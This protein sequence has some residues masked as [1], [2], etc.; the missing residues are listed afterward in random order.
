MDLG[1]IRIHTDAGAQAAAE[2]LRAKAFTVGLDIAFGR[3]QYQP[4]SGQGR[5]L[6]AHELSHV[7]LDHTGIHRMMIDN[8]ESSY[9]RAE[10]LRPARERR[11]KWVGLVEG[12]FTPELGR[13]TQTVHE[14]L[15]RTR[16][17]V[18]AQRAAA[19]DAAAGWQGWLNWELIAQGYT[20]PD[21]KEL[22]Q[23]WGEAFVAAEALAMSVGHGDVSGDAMLVA[24]AT[25][26]T[27][28]GRLAGFAKVVERA[29]QVR[30]DAENVRREATYRQKL[31][32]YELNLWNEKVQRESGMA[33]EPG[34]RA[35]LGG[36]AL[37]RGDRPSPPERVTPP[38]GVTSEIPA[39][40]ARI[41]AAE[42]G[43][44][45]HTVAEDLTRIG[46][47]FVGLVIATLPRESEARQGVEYVEKLEERLARLETTYEVAERIPAVFYPEDRIITKPGKDGQTQVVAEAI[48]WQFYLIDTGVRSREQPAH[49]G[50]EWI[51][52]DIT[53]PKHYDNKQPST[54]HEAA[55]FQQGEINPP[56][57]LF[58][59]LNSRLR[60]PKGRLYFKLGRTN[61]ILETTEPW[62]LSDF[63]SALSMVLGAI[64]LVAMV[65][66]TGGAAAPAAVAFIAG[67]GAIGAGI[68][69]QVARMHELSEQGA[70][71]DKDVEEAMIS[72][73]IDLVSLLSMG[74]GRLVAAPRTAARLGFT[75]ERFIT[76][77]KVTQAARAGAVLGDLYQGYALTKGL[78]D[79]FEAIET[80]PGL[81]KKSGTR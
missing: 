57:S 19:L 22:K 5:L 52:I 49:S 58:S 18:I 29:H 15:E 7:L 45:W 9:E 13:Q 30:A 17:A 10:R 61:Y 47:R 81:T 67:T 51:L 35:A 2:Q 33:S 56:L 21:L 74:L 68:G 75:G 53:S 48:P 69:S 43:P 25:I 55:M 27:F 60:F 8:Y 14:E 32:Q 20:G 73:G 76:L 70:L 39:A 77:Q 11:A 23:D 80:Q 36:M 3:G 42:G 44:E 6:L 63:F 62:S 16:Y 41:Y 24:L 78:I 28:Y 34:G 12:Q 1:D 38:P 26:P 37:A 72:I 64:A 31:E 40:T 65:A 71:T 59:K 46:N 54:D 66:A 50:G 4:E 79:A